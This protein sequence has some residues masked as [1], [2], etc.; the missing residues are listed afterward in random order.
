V[1]NLLH[2]VL[3]V[4]CLIESVPRVACCHLASL[5]ANRCRSAEKLR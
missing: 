1:L 5:S 2:I 3:Q 4:R